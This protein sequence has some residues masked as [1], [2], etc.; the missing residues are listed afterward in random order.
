M[1]VNVYFIL[2]VAIIVHLV[3]TVLTE[4][5]SVLSWRKRCIKLLCGLQARQPDAIWYWDAF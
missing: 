4:C 3:E 2:I 5:G 1:C